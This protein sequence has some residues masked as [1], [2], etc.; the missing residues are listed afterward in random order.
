MYKLV[1]HSMKKPDTSKLLSP[2]LLWQ[3]QP[4]LDI[5]TKTLAPLAAVSRLK[6]PVMIIAGSAD[7]HT[8]LSE[9][10]ELFSHAP[11]PKSLWIIK[12]AAHE[13]LHQFSQKEYEY[14]ILRF[15]KQYLR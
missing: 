14:R 11:E 8:L 6:S 10:K 5:S 9:S 2:L 4:R 1:E 3:I 7:R 12:G 13:D 15:L